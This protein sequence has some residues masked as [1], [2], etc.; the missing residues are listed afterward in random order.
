MRITK[1]DYIHAMKKAARDQ[2]GGRIHH[3]VHKSLKDYDRRGNKI[4]LVELDNLT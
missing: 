3:V 1:K 2:G 4:R